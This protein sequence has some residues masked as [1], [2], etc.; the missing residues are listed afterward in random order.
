MDWRSR[1]ESALDSETAVLATPVASSR[2]L[3]AVSTLP[4]SSWGSTP[5]REASAMSRW[6]IARWPRCRLIN[7]PMRRPTMRTPAPAP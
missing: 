2:K 1:D 7:T 3:S 6:A 4:L 5:S